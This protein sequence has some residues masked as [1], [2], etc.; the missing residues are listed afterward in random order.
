MR[1]ELNRPGEFSV[2]FQEAS[3]DYK[4]SQAAAA[5]AT[6]GTQGLG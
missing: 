3:D 5:S 1:M 4:E 6:Q 2:C